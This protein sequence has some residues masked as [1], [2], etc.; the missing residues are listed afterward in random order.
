ML[1][2]NRQP[3]SIRAIFIPSWRLDY[4]PDDPLQ[5]EFKE[6]AIVDFE[7]PIGNV[8]SV[9]GIDADQMSVESRVMEFRQR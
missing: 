8:N 4:L 6:W 5:A 2:P 9:I 3:V 1:E 7:K